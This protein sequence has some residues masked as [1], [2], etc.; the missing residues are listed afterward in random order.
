MVS[1]FLP[2]RDPA[3]SFPEAISTDERE[4]FLRF[5]LIPNTTALLPIVQLTEVL[6]I[7]MGQIIP[8]PHMP[9]WIMGVYNWRGQILWMIDLGQLVGLTP[10]HQ[11]ATN[12]SYYTA[13]VLHESSSQNTGEIAEN[14]LLGLVVNRVEEIE[15]CNLELIQSPP[16]NAVNPHLLPFL[17]GYWVKSNGEMLAVLEGGAIMAAMPQ[18][19]EVQ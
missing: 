11:Q 14:K 16:P 5:Y 7:P 17:R 13:I 1:D 12:S 18:T 9:A 2:L 15:W 19:N 10:R 3:L 6:T 8:I 4:Q